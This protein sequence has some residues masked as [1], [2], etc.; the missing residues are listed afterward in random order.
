MNVSSLHPTTHQ[1]A[2]LADYPFKNMFICAS[3]TWSDFDNAVCSIGKDMC[4]N[5]KGLLCE[6]QAG[7]IEQVL[8]AYRNIVNE[9]SRL[10][11]FTAEPKNNEERNAIQEL[12]RILTERSGKQYDFVKEVMQML[13]WG[14]Q[15]G[16]VRS[17][18]ILY[19]RNKKK[20]EDNR[21]TSGSGGITEGIGNLV[22][23]GVPLVLIAGA[24]ILGFKIYTV[25]KGAKAIT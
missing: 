3:G 23:Y 8:N 6:I 13:Y 9:D 25:V 10:Y 21:D 19:P 5:R 18:D 16:R 7:D 20:Y 15:D 4:Y 14:T 11:Q 12:L 24:T 2:T 1:Q 22:T 17:S